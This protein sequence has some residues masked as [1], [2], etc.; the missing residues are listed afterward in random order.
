MNQQGCQKIADEVTNH[1]GIP[2]VII[3]V[4]EEIPEKPRTMGQTRY[5]WKGPTTIVL[6]ELSMNRFNYSDASKLEVLM[7]EL[8]H[9][10][11]HELKIGGNS[12]GRQWRKIAVELGAHPR[13]KAGETERAAAIGNAKHG[14]LP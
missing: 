4:I 2:A 1:Y 5:T 7:H 8:A 10:V 14:F 3:Q 6:C 13:A 11:H 12:H 9:H